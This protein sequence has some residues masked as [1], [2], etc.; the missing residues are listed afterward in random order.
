MGVKRTIIQFLWILSSYFFGMGRQPPGPGLCGRP[1]PEEG[2][3][4]VL[5]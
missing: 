4:V 2:D 1:S 5:A 3:E